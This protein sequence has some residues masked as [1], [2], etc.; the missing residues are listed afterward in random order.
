MATSKIIG[1]V[2]TVDDEEITLQSPSI[3]NGYLDDLKSVVKRP[4]LNLIKDLAISAPVTGQF[5]WTDGNQVIVTQSDGTIWRRD[6]SGWTVMSTS[7]VTCG[8]QPATFASDGT[9]LLIASGGDSIVQLTKTGTA[10]SATYL[11]YGLTA[12]TYPGEGKTTDGD[13]VPSYPPQR[14][15]HICFYDGYFIANE[16]GTNLVHFTT[17]GYTGLWAGLDTFPAEYKP[18]D[19]N[20]IHI[21]YHEIY[22]FGE[23]S[24][25]CWYNSAQ[26]GVGTIPLAR[27]EGSQMDV[28]VVAQYSIV[29]SDNILYLLTRDRKFCAIIGREIQQVS[30]D[31]QKTLDAMTVVSDALAIPIFISGQSFI[32]LQFPTENKSWIYNTKLKTWARWTSGA[33][34]AKMP[35]NSAIRVVDSSFG[36]NTLG[37]V[38]GYPG[39]AVTAANGTSTAWVGL[40]NILTAPSYNDERLFATNTASIKSDFIRASNFGLAVPTGATIKGIG[41]TVQFEGRN[42]SFGDAYGDQAIGDNGYPKFNWDNDETYTEEHAQLIYNG[43]A[44]AYSDVV[45]VSSLRTLGNRRYITYGGNGVLWNQT[46]L[47]AAQINNALFGVQWSFTSTG[48]NGVVKVLSV[49]ITVYYQENNYISSTGQIWLGDST[50]GKIYE[51]DESYYSDVLTTG[52]KTPIPYEIE[53]GLLN[54]GTLA[55]KTS[56]KFDI[57]CKTKSGALRLQWK[58]DI[59]GQYNDGLKID[60]ND[61]MPSTGRMGM[62]FNRR[63]KISHQDDTPFIFIEGE[64]TVS[65]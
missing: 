3:I 16:I 57:R 45:P 56:K 61:G 60:T 44:L 21:A 8:S 33:S 47:S 59:S 64:E 9:V 27:I 38:S 63:Y 36:E 11:P 65:L 2:T 13:V 30:G 42:A 52:V 37:E 12:F 35:I 28:G 54:Y 41:V 18:D 51:L 23:S 40:A 49:E 39:T 31:I 32:L 50:T 55:R 17:A 29:S 46:N 43:T 20:A 6:K 25:E 62:Y 10:G 34:G 15:S 14:C 26:T 58:D 7:L 48:V 53:S 22:C 5:N 1:A 19:V 24:I 4:G